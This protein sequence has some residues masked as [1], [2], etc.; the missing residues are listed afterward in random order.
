MAPG[1][2]FATGLVWQ[3]IFFVTFFRSL[4]GSRQ[5]FHSGNALPVPPGAV[6]DL[7]EFGIHVCMYTRVYT[8][9]LQETKGQIPNRKQA[10]ANEHEF[11]C[12][13]FRAGLVQVRELGL[14]VVLDLLVALVHLIV[15]GQGYVGGFKF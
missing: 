6:V 4:S 1:G 5:P 12:L 9:G 2:I 15:P 7:R 8:Y 3:A 13:L 10:S 14:F 11:A